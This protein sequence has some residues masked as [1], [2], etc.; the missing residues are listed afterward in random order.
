MR[1]YLCLFVLFAFHTPLCLAEVSLTYQFNE[2]QGKA[3]KAYKLLLKDGF[4]AVKQ[5]G[6][7]GREEYLFAS[8]TKQLFLVDHL[9]KTVSVLDENQIVDF[10]RQAT[11]LKP[12]IQGFGDQLSKLNPKQR[13]KWEAMLGGNVSLDGI[14]EATK[15]QEAYKLVNQGQHKSALGVACQQ[16]AVQQGNLVT[17]GLC[18]AKAEDLK[19]S[20]ADYASLQALFGFA[21]QAA[22]QA[23]GIGKLLGLK[24]PP[25]QFKGLEGVPVEAKEAKEKGL[26]LRLEKVEQGPIP[27]ENLVAPSGYKL[28]KF[29]L[30]K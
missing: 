4:V 7:V 9:K 12:I 19:I 14:G 24:L 21:Q 27:A 17:G 13:A 6:G 3:E 10:N 2:G 22:D 26:A 20:P 23:Q 18:V 1:V 30:W 28:E 11:T 16:V 15:A 8:A 5:A 25:L 29:R